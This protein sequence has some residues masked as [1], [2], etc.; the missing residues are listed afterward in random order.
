MDRS[1]VVSLEYCFHWV[2]QDNYSA[3]K[4]AFIN[5]RL[6]FSGLPPLKKNGRFQLVQ[7]AAAQILTRTRKRAHIN[8]TP[9]LKSLNHLWHASKVWTRQSLWI[10]W[11]RPFGCSKNEDKKGCGGWE[12]W[13]VLFFAE[14][15][16]EELWLECKVHPWTWVSHLPILWSQPSLFLLVRCHVHLQQEIL[17]LLRRTKYTQ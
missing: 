15:E 11:Y 8:I 13:A 3:E 9:V 4:N 2:Q 16:S 1:R 7:N 10:L 5:S 14:R 17:G 6:D 12:E